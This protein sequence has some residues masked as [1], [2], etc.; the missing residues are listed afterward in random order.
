MG[1]SVRVRGA[2]PGGQ[3]PAPGA[4]EAAPVPGERHEWGKE[5][6]GA[7]VVRE[8]FRSSKRRFLR[9][10]DVVLFVNGMIN[11]GRWFIGRLFNV[12]KCVSHWEC[13]NECVVL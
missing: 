11:G 10:S 6:C 5:N 8:C 2:F 4:A 9:G 3:L 1:G 12:I 13:I 7:Q